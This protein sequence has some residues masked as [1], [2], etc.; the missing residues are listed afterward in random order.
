[1][2]KKYEQYDAVTDEKIKKEEFEKIESKENRLITKD[3]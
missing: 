1:M 2:R 3:N